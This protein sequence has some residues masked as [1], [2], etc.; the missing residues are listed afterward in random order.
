MPGGSSPQASRTTQSEPSRQCPAAILRRGTSACVR[1][2]VRL[3]SHRGFYPS[4]AMGVR[5]SCGEPPLLA[6][7]SNL[8]TRSP[9]RR[10]TH[11]D[12]FNRRMA[13][14]GPR[15]GRWPRGWDAPREICANTRNPSVDAAGQP[16]QKHERWR[17]KGDGSQTLACNAAIRANASHPS[18]LRTHLPQSVR[19]SL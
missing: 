4:F 14:S 3:K 19:P 1:H 10:D 13:Q 9:W 12:G 5:H 8:S 6:V 18:C 2:A 16:I 7:G 17:D 11:P 15:H